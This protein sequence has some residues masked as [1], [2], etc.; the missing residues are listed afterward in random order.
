MMLRTEKDYK[1]SAYNDSISS[2][3][4]KISA[5][6]KIEFRLF[7]N[8]G[9]KLIDLTS[10][11]N[12]NDAVRY[13]FLTEYL[14]EFDGYVK[15][16]SIGNI[17]IKGLSVR[18]AEKMLEEKYAAFYV[19]PFVLL[20]VVNKRIIVFPG[21]PGGAKV[22]SLTNNNTTL[23]EGLALSG[24]ISENGRAKR[25]KLIREKP[26]APGNPDVF[27][28]DLST[29]YGI[30]QG[31]MILQANDIVYVEPRQNFSSQLLREITPVLSLLTSA[32]LAYGLILQASK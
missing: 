16:P 7:S 22:I 15:L 29:I 23:I 3:T 5:N 9:F 27:L 10:L 21:T 14:V 8:D 12:P 30:K 2:K 6:D 28:I 24:G 32:L 25:I 1:Y 26:D 11:S 13:S 19:K 4:Y 18:Q 31:S 20:K 17:Y